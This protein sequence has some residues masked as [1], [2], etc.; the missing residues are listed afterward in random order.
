[1]QTPHQTAVP[2]KFCATL[3]KS[4]G[5]RMNDGNRLSIFPI[6]MRFAAA[7]AACA[8]ACA[9]SVGLAQQGTTMIALEMTV[10]AR[11]RA[12]TSRAPARRAGAMGRQRR[13][14]RPHYIEQTSTERTDRFPLAI[15]TAVSQERRRIRPFQVG[16]GQGRSGR[17]HCHAFGRRRQL[18]RRARQCAGGQCAPLQGR[19]GPAP[20][21]RR[22]QPPGAV[23]H[24]AAE[25]VC[26]RNIGERFLPAPIAHQ[27]VALPVQRHDPV[28]DDQ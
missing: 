21:V 19:E 26:R 4:R 11:R 3:A 28:V 14:R 9:A 17:R 27:Q 5:L 23:G 8:V 22:R 18:L 15:Y 2:S 13:W 7:L 16:G 6:N 12:S 24:L 25:N 20:A 1:M 10:A